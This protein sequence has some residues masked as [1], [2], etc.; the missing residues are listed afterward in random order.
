MLAA[1]IHYADLCN[2]LSKFQEQMQVQIDDKNVSA[3]YCAVFGVPGMPRDG[4][5]S[6]RAKT[7]A[8]LAD[9]AGLA[10]DQDGCTCLHLLARQCQEEDRQI[11]QILMPLES[12]KITKSGESVLTLAA[13]KKNRVFLEAALC[14]ENSYNPIKA[15]KCF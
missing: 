14:P 13:S 8:R 2:V 15:V 7:V 12:D 9:Q 1:G 5:K 4:N 3:L 6:L 10:I 11:I